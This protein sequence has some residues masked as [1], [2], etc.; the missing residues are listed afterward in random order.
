M[1]KTLLLILSIVCCAFF[2]GVNAQEYTAPKREF[3]GAWLSTVWAIDWPGNRDN[4]VAAEKSQKA[5]M[6]EILDRYQKANMNVCFFQ[7]RGFSDAF[8]RCV[9]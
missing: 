6:I 5:Q 3:R 4:T 7:V 8:F 1:K 9:L 2:V